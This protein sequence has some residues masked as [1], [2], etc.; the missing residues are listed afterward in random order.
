MS[1]H[2]DHLVH[3]NGICNVGS[4]LHMAYGACMDIMAPP[5]KLDESVVPVT[6]KAVN[7]D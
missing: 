2:G 1:H 7:G 4:A 5:F 3:R 6:L